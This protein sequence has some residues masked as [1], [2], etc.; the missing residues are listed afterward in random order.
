MTVGFLTGKFAPLHTGHIY[1]I[2]KAATMVDKLY[3]VLSYD[4]KRF[5]DNPRLSLSK[6]SSTVAKDY[7][8]RSSTYYSY[9]C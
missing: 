1:F 5:Q 2:S 7:I 4:G 8:Q 3:V 9:F 6:E